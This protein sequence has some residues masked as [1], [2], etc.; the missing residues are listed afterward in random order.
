MLILISFHWWHCRQ[1]GRTGC[2]RPELKFCWYHL[3]AGGCTVQNRGPKSP[4]RPEFNAQPGSEASGS[5][6]SWVSFLTVGYGKLYLFNILRGRHPWER[7]R[8]AGEVQEVKGVLVNHEL[9]S[10][11]RGSDL[12]QRPALCLLGRWKEIKNQN[13]LNNPDFLRK[14]ICLYEDHIR[15]QQQQ[16]WWKEVWL[17]NCCHIMMAIPPPVPGRPVHECLCIETI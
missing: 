5:K 9:Q 10:R 4:F 17:P 13:V 14:E 16:Q 6:A 2:L 15:I 12:E 8:A 3:P 11:E 1:E 7:G